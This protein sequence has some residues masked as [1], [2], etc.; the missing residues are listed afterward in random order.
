V[1]DVASRLRKLK[2]LYDGKAIT[3]DE[4]KKERERILKEGGL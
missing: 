2:A 1:E 4:Y 3:E